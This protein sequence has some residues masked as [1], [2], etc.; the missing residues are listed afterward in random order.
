MGLVG[1]GR[2]GERQT[3]S[4]NLVGPRHGRTRGVRD[5]TDASSVEKKMVGGEGKGDRDTDEKDAVVSAGDKRMRAGD[6]DV[7]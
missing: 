2:R 7:G 3:I 4:D 6:L 5:K 1:A